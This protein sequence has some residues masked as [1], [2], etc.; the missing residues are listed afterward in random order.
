M[1]HSGNADGFVGKLGN[2]VRV[3]YFLFSYLLITTSKP[4]YSVLAFIISIQVLIIIVKELAGLSESF[5]IGSFIVEVARW[6]FFPS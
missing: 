1:C 4:V 2:Q 3:S 5:E 6:L